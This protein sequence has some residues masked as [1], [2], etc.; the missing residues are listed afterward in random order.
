ML[1]SD[2][3]PEELIKLFWEL[4]GLTALA[5]KASYEYESRGAVTPQW[6]RRTFER[7]GDVIAESVKAGVECGSFGLQLIP[8]AFEVC[9]NGS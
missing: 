6:T 8:N 3:P 1:D 2:G 9:R 7:V 5:P 4:E